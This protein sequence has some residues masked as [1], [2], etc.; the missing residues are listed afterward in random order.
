METLLGA[1]W[2]LAR[3][4]QDARG[5]GGAGDT[6]GQGL[7]PRTGDTSTRGLVERGV[8][9]SAAPFS[10][11]QAR[12]A[13][14]HLPARTPAPRPPEQLPVPVPSP[15]CPHSNSPSACAPRLC[16][17]EHLSEPLPRVTPRACVPHP[18]PAPRAAPGQRSPKSCLLEG[19]PALATLLA[20]RAA[21]P[22][23]PRFS[24]AG[25]GQCWGRGCPG[26]VLP[27][28]MPP[29]GGGTGEQAAPI[30]QELHWQGTAYISLKG[31]DGRQDEGSSFWVRPGCLGDPCSTRGHRG[32]AGDWV[33]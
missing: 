8:S 11:A 16:L 29:W 26:P 12:P 24:W 6:L 1:A 5:S 4:A 32:V 20:P 9:G 22:A 13:S 21:L 7:S 15:S 31:F 23:P 33:L 27:V 2:D 18:T 17:R 25:P 3:Q 28:G 14:P 30:Q 19:P 10:M